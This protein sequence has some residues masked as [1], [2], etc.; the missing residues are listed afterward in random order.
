MGKTVTSP[1]QG[2]S[3]LSACKGGILS[4]HIRKNGPSSVPLSEEF[5][6]RLEDEVFKLPV[7]SK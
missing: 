4:P 7:L 6:P 2:V 5:V 3:E 1:C